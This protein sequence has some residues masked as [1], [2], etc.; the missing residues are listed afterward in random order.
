[1]F[2]IDPKVGM[3]FWATCYGLAVVDVYRFAIQVL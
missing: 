2:E 3:I 1:M